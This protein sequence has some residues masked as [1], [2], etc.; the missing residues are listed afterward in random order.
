MIIL[1]TE[2]INFIDWQM[3]HSDCETLQDCVAIYAELVLENLA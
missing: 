2:Q 3:Q 1:T